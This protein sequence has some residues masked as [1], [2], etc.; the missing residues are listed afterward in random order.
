MANCAYAYGR[1]ACNIATLTPDTRELGE[2]RRSMAISA[3]DPPGTIKGRHRLGGRRCHP[4]DYAGRL[5]R[6][7]GRPRGLSRLLGVVD[8]DMIRHWKLSL[9]GRYT[10]MVDDAKDSPIVDGKDARGSANQLFAGTMISY[11]W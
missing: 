7:G 1:R 6:W 10:P 8:Y 9:I 3:G 11:G 5:I 2:K 4:S